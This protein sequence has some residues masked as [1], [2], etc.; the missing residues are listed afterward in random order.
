M[1]RSLEVSKRRA[2]E[3]N[4]TMEDA[5]TTEETSSAKGLDDRC[6]ISLSFSTASEFV[7]SHTN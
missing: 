4:A 1:G 5:A 7:A 6:L 3:L 2:V